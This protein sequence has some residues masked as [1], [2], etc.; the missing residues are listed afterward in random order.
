MFSDSDVKD[1]LRQTL[2][3]TIFE[4]LLENHDFDLLSLL[5]SLYI[6]IRNML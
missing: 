5:V 6:L 3:K 2:S 4:V 1:V